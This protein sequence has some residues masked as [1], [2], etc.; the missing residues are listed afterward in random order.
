MEASFWRYW[1]HALLDGFATMVSSVS[2]LSD[3]TEKGLA[4]ANRGDFCE[5]LQGGHKTK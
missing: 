2:F 3:S 1:W 5:S 4:D